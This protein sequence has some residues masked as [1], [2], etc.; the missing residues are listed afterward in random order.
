[1]ST[2]SA[3]CATRRDGRFLSRC[4]T[5]CGTQAGHSKKVVA[6][7]VEQAQAHARDDV[8]VSRAGEDSGIVRLKIVVT[9][10]QLRQMVAGMDQGRRSGAAAAASLELEL[11]RHSL[12]RRQQGRRAEKGPLCRDRW[13]PRLQS[14]PEEV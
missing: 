5:I 7:I 1:M 13:R 4:P 14:I 12:R 10:K 2:P 9:K 11:L 3:T 6:V 8:V